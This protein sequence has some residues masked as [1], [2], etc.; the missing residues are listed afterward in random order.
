MSLSALS[1]TR[2][3]TCHPSL[4]KLVMEVSKRCAVMVLYGHRTQVE[5]DAAV[6][7]GHS[8]LAWPHSRH[9]SIPAEA[10]D[11]APL[12]IDWLNHDAFK[13]L[14]AVVE[15][16]AQEQGVEI[17]WGGKWMMCDMPHY[18][19][20]RKCQTLSTDTPEKGTSNLSTDSGAA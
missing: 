3:G 16:V 15:T 10:V 7:S 20:K 5:Q 13:K 1:L 12:P 17:E 14:A 19:L 2:L 8:K 18:Q 6:K 9:N 11:I 4:Q